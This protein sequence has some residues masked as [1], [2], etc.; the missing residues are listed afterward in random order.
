MGLYVTNTVENIIQN[1]FGT[2]FSQISGF[3][4]KTIDGLN[5]ILNST[6]GK[7]ALGTI[8]GWLHTTSSKRDHT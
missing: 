4:E 3:F 6:L 7:L 2:F 8:L 1:E 5:D